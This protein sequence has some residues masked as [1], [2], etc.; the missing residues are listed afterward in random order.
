[1]G[2]APGSNLLSSSQAGAGNR[3][4]GRPYPRQGAGGDCARVTIHNEKMAIA[5]R[6]MAGKK[7]SGH[8]PQRVAA[9]LRSLSLPDK[10]SMRLR[11]LHRRLPWLTGTL[12]CLRPGMHRA[13]PLVLQRFPEPIG[14]LAAIPGQPF[15]VG[16][17]ATSALV[18]T[19]PLACPAATKK[20]NRSPRAVTDGAKLGVHAASGSIGAAAAPAF[21]VPCRP[22][23][24]ALSDGSRRSPRSS[25]LHVRR[26]DPP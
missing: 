21:P 20:V 7:T 18:P 19:R 12:R 2:P 5:A 23:S 17:A 1:M 9:R 24:G 22:Q 14:I 25:A 10:I 13:H 8:L 15:D 6:A 16:Q 3:H 4:P 11:R 26:P